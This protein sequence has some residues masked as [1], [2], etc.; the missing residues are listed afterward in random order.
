MLVRVS[1]RKDFGQQGQKEDLFEEGNE[2][3]YTRVCLNQSLSQ[4]SHQPRDLAHIPAGWGLPASLWVKCVTLATPVASTCTFMDQALDSYPG[5][6]GLHLPVWR[7]SPFSAPTVHHNGTGRARS[8][9][10]CLSGLRVQGPLTGSRKAAG[11]A[12]RAL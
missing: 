12:C 7:R 10:S 4:N 11:E 2:S 3:L 1:W 6:T 8:G 5:C 9:R